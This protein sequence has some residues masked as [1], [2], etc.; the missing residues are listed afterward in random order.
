MPTYFALIGVPFFHLRRLEGM[1][2][3][4]LCILFEVYLVQRKQHL[5]TTIGCIQETG[6]VI[7]FKSSQ[8][9]KSEGLGGTSRQQVAA[10]Q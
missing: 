3:H 6:S 2:F 7:L 1:V 8:F 4:I 9:P 10:G 5:D